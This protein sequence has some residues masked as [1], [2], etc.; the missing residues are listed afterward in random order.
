MS[1][2]NGKS[3]FLSHKRI[4][5]KVGLVSILIPVTLASIPLARAEVQQLLPTELPHGEVLLAQ[6]NSQQKRVALVIG[7]SDYQEGVPLA[8]PVNDANDMTTAL[9]EL[10]FEVIKVINASKQE[11]EAAL[12][13][14]YNKIQAGAVSLF[15]Y[16]GH[17]IQIKDANYLIPVDAN[18]TRES[19]VPYQTLPL[20]LVID[21]MEEIKQNTN[22]II[23]DASRNDP[24]SR[25]WRGRSLYPQLDG[26]A[27]VELRGGTFIAFATAPGNTADDGRG[28]NGTFTKHILENIRTPGL[29]IEQLFKEVRKGVAAETGS[30]QIPWDNSSLIDDFYFQSVAVS[31]SS[32]S[33]STAREFFEIAKN[34]AEKEDYEGAI[35]DYNQAIRLDPDNALAYKHRGDARRNLEDYEEA[36]AD[37]TEAI[38][39]D[40]EYAAAYNNRGVVRRQ[41]GD[42]EEAI[43]DFTEAIQASGNWGKGSPTMGYNNRGFTRYQLGD[44]QEAIADYTEAIRL[45]PNYADAY[46][47]RGFARYQLGDNQ[48]AIADYTEAIRLD[49]NYADAYNNRGFARYQLGDN[50]G[51]ITDVTEG[52]RLDPNYAEAY[53]GRGFLRYKLGDYQGAI[54]DFRKAANLYLE[55]GNTEMYQE[56]LDQL[57]KLE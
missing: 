19:E 29:E 14:F 35:E 30:E 44:N 26:L 18:P 2:I 55:Q 56:V 47:N 40:P 3:D 34:K 45:D 11:M 51:A 1:Q 8:N 25:R 16:A 53:Y 23:L 31:S 39:L 22:I 13:R 57:Q 46:N 49:P 36:M 7:N 38:R 33:S 54:A 37:Y 6:R 12:T 32:S 4:I 17:G 9:E 42:Y 41:L 5:A 27:R 50:Q 43:A 15:Y 48:G 24:F 52:I 10:D 28:K 20:N 21:T